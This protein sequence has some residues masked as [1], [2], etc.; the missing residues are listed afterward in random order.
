MKR[1]VLSLIL[2]S[3]YVSV[4]ASPLPIPPNVWAATQTPPYTP[5]PAPGTPDPTRPWLAMCYVDE[6]AYVNCQWTLALK[7][8]ECEADVQ[9]RLLAGQRVLYVCY[10]LNPI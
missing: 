10:E 5:K 7:K 8:A 6:A 3:L 2:S 9:R 1:L 4:S